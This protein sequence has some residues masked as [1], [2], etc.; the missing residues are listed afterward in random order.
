MARILVTGAAGFIG[1]ALARALSAR[2][3]DL[4]LL[5]RAEGD[6]SVAETW[7]K[8]PAVEHVY[9]LAARSYVPDSWS[10]PADFLQGN[11]VGTARALDYCR[12]CSA[13]LVYVSA[14]VYGVP[15]RL[16]VHEDDE[17]EPNNPYALSKLLAEKACA[18]HAAA[19]N[20]PVTILRPFNV[21]GGGQRAE[22]LI[23]TILTQIRNGESIKVKD[24]APRRD[25]IFIDDMVDA[26]LRSIERPDGLRLFNIGAGISH[27]V[28][29]IIAIAQS[30]AGTALPVIAA[31]NPRLNEIPDVRA[32]ISRARATLGWRPAIDLADGIA[33]L[34]R[35]APT[36][37]PP[38]D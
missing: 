25:Y 9:H 35:P 27:S 23:P 32:D 5:S 37:T 33:R 18:F 34:L 31:G 1:R 36:L 26:L 13:H 17:A 8:L 3:H 20:A 38:T 16:P 29:D 2:E 21:F 12:R 28:G 19:L 15:K 11:V 4:I 14:Y 24:L 6:V 7:A 30:V 22:F 10:E